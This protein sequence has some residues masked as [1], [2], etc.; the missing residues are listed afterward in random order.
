MNTSN[1]GGVSK[2]VCGL[3]FCCKRTAAKRT[4]MEYMYDIVVVIE[5]STSIF[6]VR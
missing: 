2:N 5:I 4:P 6:V 1:M 3:D